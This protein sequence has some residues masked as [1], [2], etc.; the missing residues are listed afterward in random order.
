MLKISFNQFDENGDGKIQRSEF[1]SAYRKFFPGQNQDEV[2][3]R[4]NELFNLADID[5]NDALDF[6]EWCTATINQ[7]ELHS[8]QNMLAAFQLF[9]RDG[10]GTIEAHEIAAILGQNLMKEEVWM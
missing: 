10:N 4:A 3:D 8:R 5:G 6:A 1:L 2:D 9:D 7:H